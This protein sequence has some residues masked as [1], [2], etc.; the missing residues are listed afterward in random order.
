MGKGE[1]SGARGAA[2]ASVFLCCTYNDKALLAH[3]PAGEPAGEGVYTVT[4]SA[5]G[6]LDVL[7]AVSA[8]RNPAFVLRHPRLPVCYVSTERIDDD[9]E[10]L[11]FSTAEVDGQP[12]LKFVSKR[13]AVRARDSLPSLEPL[14]ASTHRAHA[15]SLSDGQGLRRQP[16]RGRPGAAWE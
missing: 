15:G 1:G 5:E 9:G 12:Q 7:G 14:A 2:P 10:V 6:R 11:C 16:A 8:G 13:S 3:T 4:L